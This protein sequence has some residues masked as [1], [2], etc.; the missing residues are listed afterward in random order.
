M[1]R[2]WFGRRLI[3]ATST[4]AA[5][6][7]WSLTC[8]ITAYL[9][10]LTAAGL[11]CPRPATRQTPALRILVLVPAHDEEHGIAATL[12]SLASLD[13]PAELC[14]VHVVADNCADRTV[15]VV[16]ARDVAVHVRAAPDD[17]GKG[18][19]LNWLRDRL[20]ASGD[21]FDAVAVVDADTSVA[22]G[23]L[24]EVDAVI[25]SG[26]PVVQGYYSVRRPE[27]S[28]AASFR[29]AAL[30][31]RHYLRPLGRTRLGGSCGLYGNGM[32]FARPIAL[33]HDWTGHLVE[34]AELQ[35]EL[36]LEGVS[37]AFAPHAV[38]RA[39]MPDELEAARSQ[40]ARWE[41]GRIDLARR[42]IPL[43]ARR[44]VTG[45]QRLAAADALLDHCTPPLSTLAAVHVGGLA[46]ATFGATLGSRRARTL[47]LLHLA[48]VGALGLHTVAG[49]YVAR[50]PL[51]HYRNLLGAPVQI[52]WKAR[53]WIRVVVGRERAE[54]RRTSRNPTGAAS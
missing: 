5:G 33:A 30:A 50:A 53:L 16:R 21:P 43:M 42:Y 39:E 20:V 54:W 3:G 36:L 27:A 25:R 48:G 47:G 26:S 4:G 24:R 51:A 52:A 23:F 31:C 29:Y 8:P 22:P 18:P 13:Y 11:P 6:V 45:P 40:N 32:A 37:V 7:L 10:A 15:E 28:A 1:G 19:A 41:R 35:N 14:E 49:L 46:A 17:P 38:V 9:A 44:A 12:D 2:S 34:D